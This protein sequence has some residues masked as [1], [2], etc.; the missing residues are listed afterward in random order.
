MANHKRVASVLDHLNNGVIERILVLLQPASQVVGDSGGVVDNGKGR[1]RVRSGVRLG[2]VGAF[3]KHV[4]KQ[5]GSECFISSLGEQRLLPKDGEERHWSL[6]HVNARL[7][8]HT[9]VNIGPIKT[10][11]DVLLLLKGEHVLVEEL[12]Q[13]LIDVVDTDLLEAVVVEDLEAGN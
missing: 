9:K 2:K 11:L 6:K 12:L 4:I 13:L 5:L 10:L 1:I 8:V 7:Q 3:T